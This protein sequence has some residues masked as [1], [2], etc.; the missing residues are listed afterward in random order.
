MSAKC[1]RCGV[2]SG[3]DTAFFKA[4]KSFS[5]K[6]LTYC[7]DCWTSK[8]HSDSKLGII[9][10]LAV[11]PLGLLL[12][13]AGA[14]DLGW[15]MINIV[16]FELFMWVTIMPH[17]LAHAVAARAVGMQVFRIYV[18]SG[19][20][21]FACRIGGF[22]CEFRSLPTEGLVI[23]AHRVLRNL[24][25]RHFAFVLA[26]P[27]ANFL[28]AAAVWVSSDPGSLWDFGSLEKGLAPG[29]AF[30]YANVVV[31]L[32]NLW[33]R[34][35]ATMFGPL[36][37][38]GKQLLQAFFLHSGKVELYHAGGFVTEASFLHQQGETGKALARVEEGLSLY[39]GNEMLLNWKGVLQLDHGNYEGARQC[40]LDLLEKP[41][42]PPAARPILLN[43][44]AYAD[45][46]LDRDDLLGEADSFSQ[47]AMAAMSWMPAIR[48]TR[49]TVLVA[50][51]RLEE[52]LKLLRESMAQASIP[53]D[54]AQNACLIAE[55][56]SRL[57]NYSVARNY[58]DE[59]RRLE[60]GCLLLERAESI[61]RREEVSA[62]P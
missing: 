22:D 27:A 59:A 10:S 50:M 43:N 2:E 35:V 57:G 15:V 37:S 39:S 17:E 34:D 46:L 8:Q 25:A 12:M 24:R 9:L 61:L 45:A 20:T 26:G 13:L 30:F 28:L 55:A 19:S 53:G 5:Q 6:I 4:P 48:G 56:E 23:A 40:F 58:L 18:G 38:D 51:G 54:K 29:P 32:V 60:P 47:E 16:L 33:P 36:P 7:P 49:G 41:G 62:G 11:G 52:G 21:L 31:L 14:P 1:D 3:L 44:V 42:L